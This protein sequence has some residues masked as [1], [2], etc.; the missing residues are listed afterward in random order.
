MFLL[1]IA[2]LAHSNSTSM[3]SHLSLLNEILSYALTELNTFISERIF[4][5]SNQ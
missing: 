3:L 4:N 5:L 2:W 1:N